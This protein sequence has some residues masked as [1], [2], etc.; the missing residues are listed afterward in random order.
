MRCHLFVTGG[1]DAGSPLNAQS[2]WAGVTLPA[3]A[4]VPAMRAFVSVLFI[5]ASILVA[6]AEPFVVIVRHAE[7]AADGGNDPDLSAAG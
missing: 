6:S 1:G 7:K 5:L 2:W 4:N 3:S